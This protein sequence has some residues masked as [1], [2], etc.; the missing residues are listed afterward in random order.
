MHRKGLHV[1]SYDR[2][3]GLPAKCNGAKMAYSM[4]LIFF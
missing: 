3:M 1:A 4:L 2:L